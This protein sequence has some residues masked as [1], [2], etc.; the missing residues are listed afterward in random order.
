MC[1]LLVI[2][3]FL[4]LITEAKTSSF[5]FLHLIIFYVSVTVGIQGLVHFRLFGYRNKKREDLSLELTPSV[6]FASV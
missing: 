2:F 3:K 5:Y 1:G 4:F 6:L